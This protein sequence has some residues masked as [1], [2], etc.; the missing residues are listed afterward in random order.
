[1]FYNTLPIYSVPGLVILQG[2]HK[3]WVTKIIINLEEKLNNITVGT[4]Y[5]GKLESS[6]HYWFIILI[7]TKLFINLNLLAY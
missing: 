6:S 5:L 2:L 1:M 4:Y 7:Y 3:C